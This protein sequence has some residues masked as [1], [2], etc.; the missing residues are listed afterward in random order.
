[1]SETSVAERRGKRGSNADE[2][3]WEEDLLGWEY[4]RDLL[5]PWSREEEIEEASNCGE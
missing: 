1:M 2:E 4:R 3:Q 5:A